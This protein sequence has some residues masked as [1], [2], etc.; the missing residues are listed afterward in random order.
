MCR[1]RRR[2]GG[3][4]DDG[5]RHGRALRAVA[6]RSSADDARRAAGGGVRQAPARLPQPAAG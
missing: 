6:P 5:P 2:G 3:V 4:V 1:Q